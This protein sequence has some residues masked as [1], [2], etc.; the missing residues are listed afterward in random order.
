MLLT[1]RLVF[2][3]FHLIKYYNHSLFSL[4]SH[5]LRHNF[6]LSFSHRLS[7]CLFT[8]LLK[9]RR[10]ETVRKI[11]RKGEWRKLRSPWSTAS[12]L[13]CSWGSKGKTQETLSGTPYILWHPRRCVFYVSFMLI[14]SNACT[15][16]SFLASLFS[17]YKHMHCIFIFTLLIHSVICLWPHQ[18]T[19]SPTAFALCFYLKLIMNEMPKSLEWWFYFPQ[20]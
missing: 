12:C 2:L 19:N 11:G 4:L 20:N 8:T 15:K 18:L 17:H 3:L 16:L 6:P 7:L 5:T 10:K 1:F 14:F 13:H 9:V